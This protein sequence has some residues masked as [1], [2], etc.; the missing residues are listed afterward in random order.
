MQAES[1][2]LEPV[3]RFPDSGGQ[4]AAGKNLSDI[5]RLQGVFEPRGS[6]KTE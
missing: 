5:Q 4:Q 6:R 2:L 3:V 1:I